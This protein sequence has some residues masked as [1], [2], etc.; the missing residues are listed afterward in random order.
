MT[1]EDELETQAE[2]GALPM[3][4]KVGNLMDGF[5]AERLFWPLL[6]QSGIDIN[7]I[8]AKLEKQQAALRLGAE[9]QRT[10]AIAHSA[11]EAVFLQQ[12]LENLRKAVDL[13][14][15]ASPGFF[16]ILDT[17]TT[18]AV[19]TGM[20]L[21]QS[22][23]QAKN[24]WAKVTFVSNAV[25]DTET[26]TFHFFWENPSDYVAV[27]NGDA[28]ILAHGFCVALHDGSFFP[29]SNRTTLTLTARLDLDELWT[30]PASHP[31]SSGNETATIY[32][33]IAAIRGSTQMR[34]RP[35]L[36]PPPPSVLCGGMSATLLFWFLLM[37]G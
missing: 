18:I 16:V 26:V 2:Q 14:A 4:R 7:R 28:Y 30:D 35:R 19:T 21:I 36:R 5:A 6:A 12:A 8:E 31:L 37:A 9:Q 20:R 22:R 15:G 27:I 33:L 1:K 25:G 32:S 23:L 13:L 34:F 11:Q 3:P 10:Q 29:N 17:P 24:S